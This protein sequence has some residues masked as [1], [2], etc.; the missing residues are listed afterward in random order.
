VFQTSNLTE[1]EERLSGLVFRKS[2]GWYGVDHNGLTIDCELS[3]TLRKQLLYRTT[4]GCTHPATDPQGC[5]KCRPVG[6][7]GHRS[8][9]DVAEISAVDPVAVGDI[10][11][12]ARRNDGGGIIT[13]VLPRRNTLVRRAAGEKRLKQVIAANVDQVLAVVAAM[14]P[15]P[16]WELLDRYLAAA[17]EAELPALVVITKTDLVD[18]DDLAIELEAY[19]RI[20]YPT[21]LTSSA[22]GRG[23]GELRSA[24]AGKVSLVAGKSGVGKTSLLNAVQPDLGLRVGT[25][26]ESGR[27]A[28]KGKHTTS[29]VE[30]FGLTGGGAIV[31]TPGMREFGLWDVSSKRQKQ[32]H[33][34]LDLAELFPDLRPH[35]GHCR[36]G[37]DC[38]HDH[39]PGCAVKLAV[40]RG[41][42]HDRRYR[43]YL[44]LSVADSR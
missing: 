15:A 37:L 21:V 16:S 5:S 13:E 33:L 2:Q 25:V 42:I 22:T 36:F 20:G 34:A 28:G 6:G 10:V 43:S 12:F 35:L 19:R 40:E 41:E 17:E 29:H 38:S 14:R 23:I 27:Q 39:E 4:A 24:L 31:D 3:T 1:T 30:M 18:V 32:E 9:R 44:R 26:S 11:R 7:D 8:V